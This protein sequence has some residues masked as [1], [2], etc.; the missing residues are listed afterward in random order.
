MLINLFTVLLV[1]LKLCCNVNYSWQWALFPTMIYIGFYISINIVN[2]I[3]L[4][5]YKKG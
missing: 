2:L 3:V 4:K 5:L 1:L